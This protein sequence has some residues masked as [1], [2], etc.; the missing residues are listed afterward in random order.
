[1]KTVSVERFPF[2]T[3]EKKRVLTKYREVT[4]FYSRFQEVVLQIPRTLYRSSTEKVRECKGS[5]VWYKGLIS[6]VQGPRTGNYGTHG[7][8]RGRVLIRVRVTGLGWIKS[9]MCPV[10]EVLQKVPWG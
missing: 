10:R 9:S 1:M 5:E 4:D 3:T 7:R 6:E 8:R 2:G